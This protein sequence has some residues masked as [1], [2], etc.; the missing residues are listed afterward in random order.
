MLKNTAGQSLTIFAFD[1]TTNLP[2]PGDAANI[3]AYVGIDGAGVTQLADTSATE[4]DA[5]KATGFYEFDLAQ[6]ETNGAKLEFSAESSTPNIVCIAIPAVI[7]PEATSVL[8]ISVSSAGSATDI[9]YADQNRGITK[10]IT[11]VNAAGEAVIPLTGDKI[12]AIIGRL[13]LLGTNFADAEFVV[14]SDAATANGSSFSKNTPSAG[15][16]RLRIDDDDLA[17]NP[18]VYS[19]LID[20]LDS[21]DNDLWKTVSRGIFVLEAT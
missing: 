6:A 14:T 12:R 16:N 10:D 13:G 9:V 3:A 21:N 18:G 4:K 7:Y 2:Y 1:V 8:Q 11:L 15:L 5:V 19:F 20:F 17:F